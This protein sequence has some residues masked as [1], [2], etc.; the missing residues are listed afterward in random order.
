MEKELNYFIVRDSLNYSIVGGFTELFH[1]W[2]NSLSHSIGGVI[3]E[4]M[5]N[6]G[7]KI[8]HQII[9]HYFD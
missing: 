3:Q 1:C 6:Q 8:M 2:G 7:L 4:R 9:Q 5:N